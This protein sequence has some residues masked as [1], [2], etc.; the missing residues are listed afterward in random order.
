MKI[1]LSESFD[2]VVMPA[3]IVGRLSMMEVLPASRCD[4]AYM[5]VSLDMRY[6]VQAR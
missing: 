6:T 1:I 5:D 4:W 2:I 3:P